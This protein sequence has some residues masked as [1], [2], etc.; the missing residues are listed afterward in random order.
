[1][2]TVNI[3]RSNSTNST[4]KARALSLYISS[5]SNSS[6]SGNSDDTLTVDE[7]DGF[8]T[9]LKDVNLTL[10]TSESILV[11]YSPNQG[12][13]VIVLGASLNRDSGGQV[14]NTSNKDQAL[15]A[16]LSTAAVI[17]PESLFGVTSLNMLI[18]DKPTA[19]EKLENFTKKKLASSVVVAAVQR[20]DSVVRPM[21]IALYFTVLDE[22]KPNT[23][24][25][26]LCSFY[27]NR[28][29]GWNESGCTT[30]VENTVFKRYECSCKHTTSF[31]LIWLPK[32]QTGLLNAQ[33]IASLVVQSLSILCFLA[34]IVHIVVTRCI[35]PM[36]SVKAYDLLPLISTASTSVL[37]VFYI[38][39]GMTVYTRKLDLT[40]TRCFTSA[41][42]LMFFVYFFLIF[43][44][45]IKTSVG[46][47]NYL[48][49]VLL[50]PEPSFRKLGLMLLISFFISIT[51]VSFAAGFNSD[52][53]F[54][55]TQLY[56]GKL[57]WFTRDVVYY[58]VTIPVGI[59]LVLNLLTIILVTK[60]IID[61]V[62]N[63]TSPHQSYVRMKRCILV[64]LS[65]CVT[66][67]VGWLFGPFISFVNPEAANILGWF[68]V[69]FNGLEGVWSLLLYVIVR[70]Q[71]VY[72]QKRT[73]A[74]L[75]LKT[76]KKSG[77]K[78]KIK[79]SREEEST[80]SI[81]EENRRS[82]AYEQIS[83]GG[84]RSFVNLNEL[85]AGDINVEDNG[86]STSV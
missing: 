5:T 56:Q 39:L 40:V 46:Y 12:N 76:P 61:H 54:N 18:I 44:F 16:P 38:A 67:G 25:E 36:M 77:S 52:P 71:H 60:R 14:V 86:K 85:K 28:T 9:N 2:Y 22:Y 8:L 1:M 4:D 42:V 3:L 29:N 45:C 20:N 59:F 24:V 7:I 41:S 43:M 26:Y 62:R 75:S 57:C 82:T 19:F 17:S 48:R 6:I 34:I 37:F 15:S 68:F 69:I 50:F 23:S 33:D 32:G 47:F 30:P 81:A 21:N 74:A 83:S 31:A 58:F 27:D 73:K 79:S 10:S 84:E 63:A 49:F 64:L 70:T 35:N 66:Q 51:W 65:S 53:S 11:A 55:I 78:K 80:E 13:G 72:E